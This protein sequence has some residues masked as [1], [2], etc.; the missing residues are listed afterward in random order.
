[1]TSNE[2]DGIAIISN[3]KEGEEV[4]VQIFEELISGALKLPHP[5]E[6]IP[7]PF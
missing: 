6:A 1:M 2:E 3:N 5:D 7:I 4:K